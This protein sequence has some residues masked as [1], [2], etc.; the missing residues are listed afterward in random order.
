MNNAPQP[1]LI[2]ACSGLKLDRAAPAFDLYQGVM[3][4]TFRTHAAPRARPRVIILSAL[5][6]FVLPDTVLE[7]YEQKMTDGR[8]ALMMADLYRHLCDGWPAEV[9]EVLLAG[10]S[11]YRTVMRAAVEHL[12]TANRLSVSGAVVETGGGIGEQ[13]AQLGQ[14]LRAL[15]AD[16]PVVGYQPNGTPLY[17]QLGRFAVGDAVDVV[18]TASRDKPLR[19]RIDELFITPH[20]PTAC[21]SH[22]DRRGTRIPD[23]VALGNL[24]PAPR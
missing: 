7:P 16:A 11:R 21:V 5:H 9:G 8:V 17:R 24:Q 15:A 3:Y 20:G 2:L 23:W 4:S 10:G 12:R 13:R 19:A 22:P 18:W 6:G 14:W 1:L